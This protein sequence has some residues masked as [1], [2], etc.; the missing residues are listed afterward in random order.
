MPAPTVSAFWPMNLPVDVT[1]PLLLTVATASVA[2]MPNR[3]V[4]A[5]ALATLPPLITSIPAAAPTI[6]PVDVLVKSAS[7]LMMPTP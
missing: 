5:P 1:V 6:T 3:P 4:T 2:W 7:E